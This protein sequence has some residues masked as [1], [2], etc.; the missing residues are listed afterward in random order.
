MQQTAWWIT[1]GLT[2][3]GATTSTEV[4]NAASSLPNKMSDGP[5]LPFRT[6][7]HCMLTL[8]TLDTVR[9]VPRYLIN[10]CAKIRATEFASSK[11]LPYLQQYYANCNKA[12][13]T[14]FMT[15]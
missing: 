14:H 12:Y 6:Y 2:E 15:Y 8:P 5:T 13:N 3:E 4:F 11:I 7:G 1:G 9:Y 10:Y